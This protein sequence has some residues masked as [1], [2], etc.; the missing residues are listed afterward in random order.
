M[1]EFSSQ[2]HLQEL[3][4]VLTDCVFERI[5]DGLCEKNSFFFGRDELQFDYDHEQVRM[6]LR[7]L[8][9]DYVIHISVG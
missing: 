2:V 9:P 7:Y 5:S 4:G 1:M 6:N 8:V 3:T